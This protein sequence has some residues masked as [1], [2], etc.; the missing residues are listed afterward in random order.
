MPSLEPQRERLAQRFRNGRRAVPRAKFLAQVHDAHAR[1]GTVRHARAERQQAIF[2]RARVVIRLNR[3]RSRPEQRHGPLQPRAIHG[4]V[5]AVVARRLLLLVARLL[6]FVHDDQ[7]HV[8]ERRENGG[9]RSGHHARLSVPHT[10][11][12]PRALAFRQAA[13]Q[14]RDARAESRAHQAAHPQR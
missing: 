11:P 13:V 3:R 6:L 1:H 8:F 5:A 12:F 14:H 2:S 10:P 7:A 4:H 9:T